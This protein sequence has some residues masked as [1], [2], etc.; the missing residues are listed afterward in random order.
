MEPELVNIDAPLV[1][2]AV[3]PLAAVLVLGVLPLGT[4]TLFE[5]VV[6]GLE[7]KARDR[8]NVVLFTEIYG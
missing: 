2:E 6:V 4:D 1:L 7:G 3:R 8:R 5:E